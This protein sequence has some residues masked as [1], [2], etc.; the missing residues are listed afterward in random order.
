[1]HL[2]LKEEFILNQDG[3]SS[4]ISEMYM[5]IESNKLNKKLSKNKIK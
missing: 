5:S 2:C 1:M 3:F 4:K